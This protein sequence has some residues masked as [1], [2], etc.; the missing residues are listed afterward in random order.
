MDMPFAW[1]RSLVDLYTMMNSFSK[2]IY[3]KTLEDF[4]ARFSQVIFE[5]GSTIGTSER[6]PLDPIEEDRLRSQ[7]WNAAIGEKYKGRRYGTGDLYEIEDS[8]FVGTS[9]SQS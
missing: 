5:V 2:L 6:T 1:K 4:E 8:S 7:C 9:L 3:E